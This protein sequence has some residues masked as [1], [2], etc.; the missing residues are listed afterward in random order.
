MEIEVVQG[1]H[2]LRLAR[3]VGVAVHQSPGQQVPAAGRRLAGQRRAGTPAGLPRRH[4][5]LS[6]RRDQRTADRRP[7]RDRGRVAGPGPRAHRRHRRDR[8]GQDH[9]RQ[10]TGAAARRAGRPQDRTGRRRAG[11]GRGS[12]HRARQR[13]PRP[14]PADRS[15][16]RAGRRARRQRVAG[17]PARDQRP[18]APAP[19]SVAPRCR[20]ADR[21]EIVQPAGHHPRAVRAAPAGRP[22]PA[23]RDARPV[24]RARAVGAAGDATGTATPNIATPSRELARL[25]TEERERAREIDLLAFG[26]EE[27]ERV[28][29]QPGEDV[30]LAAEAERL[31]S[32]D[33]L[34]ASAGPR[35]RRW[36]GTTTRPAER[37]PRSPRRGRRRS[38]WPTLIRRP[39]RWRIGWPRP[40]TCSTDVTGDVARYLED[41]EVEPGRLEQIAER[42]YRAERADPQVRLDAATR[43]SPGPSGVGRATADAGVRPTNG[44]PSSSARIE[45]L[46]AALSRRGGRA[47]TGPAAGGAG[48]RAS[49]SAAS[50]PRWPCRRPGCVR[51]H[52]DRAGPG[53]SRPDRSAVQR[54][55]GHAA[56]QSGPGRLRR[57]AVPGPAGRSRWCWPTVASSGTLVFDEVDA[58]VGGTVAVEVGR[59]LAALARHT[60]RSSWSPTWLRSRRSPT[61]TSWWSSPTTARSPPAGS[62]PSPTQDR[63]AEL[64]RMM[65]GSETTDSALAHAGELLDL[66]RP[67]FVL[68]PDAMSAR[69]DSGAT[70]WEL[71]RSQAPC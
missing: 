39:G 51:D 42:R 55:P 20:P 70:R 29:P 62:A 4:P 11:A 17:G 38:G 40:A 33:D 8:G 56:A 50:W 64:A 6:E 66:A 32:A 24:R 26:L 67:Q 10:R 21:A 35:R 71:R 63:A 65:A 18:D 45:Q 7:G 9:D 52:R 59:R 46:Q 19:T 43:C 28:A 53:R 60:R 57:R 37:W 54:Q 30:A 13:R 58:G 48:D 36:P 5:G 2:R 61:G 12:I 34:A 3:L 44:S 68:T 27:I 1:R 25:P 23:A 22:E 49:G 16:R 15:G 14:G 69:I 41:L 31:Q 47:R